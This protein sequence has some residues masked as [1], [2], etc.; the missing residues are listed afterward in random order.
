[1]H[2]DRPALL[3]IDVQRGFDDAA[4]WGARDN[5]ACEANVAALLDH[6]RAQGW[7]I[8]FVRHDSTTPG[9][10]LAPGRPGNDFKDVVTGTPDLLV[11][12][13]VNSSFHGSPDLHAW[14]QAEGIT[15]VVVSGISTN[16]C[17]ETT[18]RVSG[19][20]GYDTYFALD[21]THSFDRTG[22]DGVRVPA[23]TLA[24]ITAT[25]LHGE[26]ATVVPTADLLA[27]R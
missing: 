6:W 12:K 7:P 25:N 9:S 19:N 4:H 8:V 18:A 10:P 2:L 21:A 14:L 26:F 11:T 15:Q 3:V 23:A 16:H 5:P 17:C 20:L 24:A 22:P 1:M 13:H 27:T